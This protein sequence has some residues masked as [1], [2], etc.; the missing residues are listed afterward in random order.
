MFHSCLSPLLHSFELTPL[1]VSIKEYVRTIV[2][3]CTTSK[4]LYS[5]SSSLNIALDP[6][7]IL[8][9]GSK[10]NLPFTITI[11]LIHM[12]KF[13]SFL[14]A[15]DSLSQPNF[16]SQ[17]YLHP[18]VSLKLSNAK[19]RFQTSNAIHRQPLR[20]ALHHPPRNKKQE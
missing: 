15:K 4:H 9:M 13:H 8:L 2:Y 1:P 12:I 14:M 5:S 6:Q 17:Y 16:Y 7:S 11:S 20:R 19:N 3:F 10:Y 18:S